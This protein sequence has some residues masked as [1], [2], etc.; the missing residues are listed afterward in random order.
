MQ[1]LSFKW[2]AD[3]IDVTVA[4]PHRLGPTIAKHFRRENGAWF[5]TRYGGPAEDATPLEAAKLEKL[6][7]A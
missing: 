4:T 2:S 5:V 7:A 6:I 3:D 1:L